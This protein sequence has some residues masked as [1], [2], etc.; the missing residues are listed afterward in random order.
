MLIDWEI[1]PINQQNHRNAVIN[2]KYHRLRHQHM[3]CN[4]CNT[5]T[6]SVKTSKLCSKSYTRRSQTWPCHSILEGTWI[7]QDPSE[8]L[9]LFTVYNV[10]NKRLPQWLFTLP[11]MSDMNE[12]AVNWQQHQLSVP[13]CNTCLG[14]QSLQVA[15]PSFWNSLPSYVKAVNSLPFF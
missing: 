12:Y 8:T 4:Q 5:D 1:T 9:F 13:K 10:I 14:A 11:I 6:T 7:A 15:E 2:L 3:D